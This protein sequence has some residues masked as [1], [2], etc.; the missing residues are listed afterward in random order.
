[1]AEHPPSLE[2]A[3]GGSGSVMPHDDDGSFDMDGSFSSQGS[4]GA[5]SGS[6]GLC[7]D[8]ASHGSSCTPL[9][10]VQSPQPSLSQSD[11]DNGAVE[12]DG[13]ASAD[14]W[15][16]DT[17]SSSHSPHSCASRSSFGNPVQATPSLRHTTDFQSD[18]RVQP[19]DVAI[20]VLTLRTGGVQR[21]GSVVNAQHVSLVQQAG[22]GGTDGGAGGVR[23]F[24][25]PP[26][27]D[28][29][30][31]LPYRA[32]ALACTCGVATACV[33]ALVSQLGFDVTNLTMVDPQGMHRSH[34]QH[35]MLF[36]VYITT[37]S[38]MGVWVRS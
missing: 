19:G 33:A 25:Q 23:T 28:V 32:P 5:G 30:P 27:L 35:L 4:S 34:C 22:S 17:H 15:S 29:L 8:A 14:G 9:D 1:M 12:S 36:S 21:S 37:A 3:G 24:H 26:R 6:P 31:W 11:S 16:T 18:V 38:H 10:G 20:G 13:A 2:E 7:A